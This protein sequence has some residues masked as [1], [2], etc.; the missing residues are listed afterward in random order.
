MGATCDAGSRPQWPVTDVLAL[1]L[2][3]IGRHGTAIERPDSPITAR[4]WSRGR[5]PPSTGTPARTAAI[6]TGP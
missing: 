1:L 2:Q 3:G 5:L 4:I 6:T